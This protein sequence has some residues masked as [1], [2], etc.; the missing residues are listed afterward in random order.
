MTINKKKQRAQWGFN[1]KQ[2][3]PITIKKTIKINQYATGTQLKQIQVNNIRCKG[4][5]AIKHQWEPIRTPASQ[6]KPH[7]KSNTN[8]LKSI[9]NKYKPMK[10][11]WDAIKSLKSQEHPMQSNKNE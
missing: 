4:I 2:Y 8:Q 10:N 11:P 6:G 5:K 9:I 1:E 3:K 7:E